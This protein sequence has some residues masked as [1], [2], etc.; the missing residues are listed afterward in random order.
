MV[1]FEHFLVYQVLSSALEVH[2]LAHSVG[3]QH[4]ASLTMFYQDELLS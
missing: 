2:F 3:H 4:H 1:A